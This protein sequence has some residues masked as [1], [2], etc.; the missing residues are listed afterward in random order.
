[1][2]WLR[3]K[4]V[5]SDNKVIKGIAFAIAYK[6]TSKGGL[7]KG[8]PINKGKLGFVQKTKTDRDRYVQE[9]GTAMQMEVI[10]MTKGLAGEIQIFI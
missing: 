6:Q 8:N 10:Q 3:I 1:M 7:G 4:G 9:M 5:S 2:N